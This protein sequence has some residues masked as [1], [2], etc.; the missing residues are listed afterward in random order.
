[1][2]LP[3]TGPSGF[4][5]DGSTS[6]ASLLLRAASSLPV[7]LLPCLQS[8]RSALCNGIMET[9]KNNVCLSVAEHST[10]L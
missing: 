4:K 1:M 2:L 3:S 6:T 10:N 9:S 5:K 7:P 8:G